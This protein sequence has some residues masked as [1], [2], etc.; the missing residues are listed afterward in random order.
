M[1]IH[2][3]RRSGG[4]DA[5]RDCQPSGPGR[6]IPHNPY[7]RWFVQPEIVD[8]IQTM[9]DDTSAQTLPDRPVIAVTELGTVRLH[10]AEAFPGCDP[11]GHWFGPAD[12]AQ[13][14]RV[15]ARPSTCSL[16]SFTLSLSLQ[17]S[18]P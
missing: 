11:S 1:V 15:S 5:F 10:G 12:T 16:S 2:T 18:L 7:H 9:T 6:P 17:G 13:L 14:G 8:R 3:P 4:A